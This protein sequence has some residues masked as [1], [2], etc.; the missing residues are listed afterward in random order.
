MLFKM[1]LLTF[2]TRL[3]NEREVES[4]SERVEGLDLRFIAWPDFRM[5][6]LVMFWGRNR[7]TVDLDACVG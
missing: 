1:G 7:K 3:G 2:L 5:I 4:V 6:N